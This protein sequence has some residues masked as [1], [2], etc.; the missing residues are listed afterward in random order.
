MNGRFVN[1]LSQVRDFPVNLFPSV[2][3]TVKL[4]LWRVVADRSCSP[5]PSPGVV[6]SRIW[7]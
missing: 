3:V 7:V 1:R 4:Y 6:S 5:D 2:V